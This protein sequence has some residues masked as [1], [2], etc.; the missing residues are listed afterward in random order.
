M[1]DAQ[2]AARARGGLE[3]SRAAI[4]QLIAA[5]HDEFVEYRTRERISRGLPPMPGGK[6]PAEIQ[7]QID[8]WEKHLTKLRGDLAAV[9]NGHVT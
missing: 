7:R 5:H 2:T 6:S 8:K 1:A 4:K 9:T 3:A